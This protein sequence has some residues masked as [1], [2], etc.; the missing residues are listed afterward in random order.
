MRPASQKKRT[1]VAIIINGKWTSFNILCNYLIMNILIVGAGD[2]GFQLASLLSKEEHDVCVID[3]D[4]TRI[5]SIREK[6]DA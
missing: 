4:E 2:V 3:N 6:I 1:S 5:N